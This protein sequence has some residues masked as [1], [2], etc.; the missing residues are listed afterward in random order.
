MCVCVCVCV[1][2][3]NLYESRDDTHIQPLCRCY[4]EEVEGHGAAVH[5]G[6]RARHHRQ[7]AHLVSQNYVDGGYRVRACVRVSHLVMLAVGV[8]LCVCM[9]VCV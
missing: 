9:R 3:V 8:M 6:G 5:A 2:H 7:D 4:R 1:F